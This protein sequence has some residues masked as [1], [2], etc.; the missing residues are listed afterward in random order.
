MKLFTM[1]EKKSKLEMRIEEA[2]D[3][4]EHEPCNSEDYEKMAKNVETLYKASSYEK[5]KGVSPDTIAVIAA[6]LL[7]IMLILHHEQLHV[8]S[9]KAF[10]MIL[11]GRV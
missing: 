3:R 6:N 5:P 9:T 4:M 10:G 2:L 11:R 1:K 8:I 7:G